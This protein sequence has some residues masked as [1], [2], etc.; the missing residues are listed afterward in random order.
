[1]KR[2]PKKELIRLGLQPETGRAVFDIKG[3][4][5]GRGGY[6]CPECISNLHLN[7]RIQRAFRNRVKEL[8]LEEALI[9]N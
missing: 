6:V 7:K 4:M 2:R 9:K 1:M 3:Q 5:H 8:Y